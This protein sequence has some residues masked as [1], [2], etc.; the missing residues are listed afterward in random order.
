MSHVWE[1]DGARGP[2]T[3]RSGNDNPLS[4]NRMADTTENIT[5]SQIR[6]NRCH[7]L[8]FHSKLFDDH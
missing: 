1:G 6:S 8:P 3:V 7:F 4:L 2:C 5:F